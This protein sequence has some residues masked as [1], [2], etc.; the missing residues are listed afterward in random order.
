MPEEKQMLNRFGKMT[1]YLGKVNYQ[2]KTPIS[3]EMYNLHLMPI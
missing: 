3:I 1:A 2:Y